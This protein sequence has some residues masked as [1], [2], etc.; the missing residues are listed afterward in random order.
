MS[1]A[2]A[3]TPLLTQSEL[4]A[5]IGVTPQTLWR[6]R[7]DGMPCIPMAGGDYFYNLEKVQ[8]WALANGVTFRQGRP[9]T[10]DDPELAVVKQKLAEAKLAKEL[11][12]TEKHRHLLDLAKGQVLKKAEVEDGRL[13]RVATVKAALLALPGKM[14]QRLAHREP[15]EIQRDLEAEVLAMLKAFAGHDTADLERCE[16]AENLA[17]AGAV[18]VPNSA[19]ITGGTNA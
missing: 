2:P 16:V 9:A 4:L 5:A 14:S 3:T 8:T 12:L 6:Y 17:Q 15:L 10:S 18:G 11:V 19:S 13:Q 7:K 1:A